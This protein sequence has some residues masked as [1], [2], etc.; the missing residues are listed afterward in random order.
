MVVRARDTS[1]GV[2]RTLEDT[3]VLPSVLTLLPIFLLILILTLAFAFVLVAVEIVLEEK[4]EV[5]VE[6]TVTE[7]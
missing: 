3:P 6:G 4:N 1:S 2:L 5:E 7:D